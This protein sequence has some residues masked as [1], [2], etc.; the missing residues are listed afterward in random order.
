MRLN[1]DQPKTTKKQDALGFSDSA[2]SMAKNILDG[3]YPKGFV[4]GIDG[5]WGS[6]K[7][8]F[9]NFV[10]E[11]LKEQ[12]AEFLKEQSDESLKELPKEFRV[13]E[14]NPWLHSSHENLIAAYF[15]LLQENS[16][17]IFGDDSDIKETLGNVIDAFAPVGEAIANAISLGLLGKTVNTIMRLC[18]KELQKKPTLESQYKQIKETLEEVKQPFLVIID[19]LDRLDKTEIKTML[20]LVKSVGQLPYVTYILAYDRDY[21]ENATKDDMPDRKTT[22]LQKII[23]YTFYIPKPDKN[24]LLA[25]LN[26]EIEEFLK[27]IDDSN[28]RWHDLCKEALHPYIK[29]PRDVAL[30]TNGI[31]FRFHAVKEI[32]DPVDFF[33]LECLRLFDKNLWDWIRDNRDII[34]GEGVYYFLQYEKETFKKDVED[35]LSK[36][37]NVSENQKTTL[38]L[39]FPNLA[40]AIDENSYHVPENNY[41]THKRNGI[42]VKSAYDAYFSQHLDKTEVLQ[43]DIDSFI[44]NSHD[45]KKTTKTLKSW[46]DKKGVQGTPK[47]GEFL[48]LLNF[49]LENNPDHKPDKMLLWS[50]IDICDDINLIA[51]SLTSFSMPIHWQILFVFTYLFEQIGKQETKEFLQDVCND[52]TRTSAATF[53]LHSVGYDMGKMLNNDDTGKK[54]F[55]IEEADW[56]PLT[57]IIAPHIKSAFLTGTVGDFAKVIFA[58]LFATH[59]F[60]DK[61]AQDMFKTAYKKSEKYVIKTVKEHLRYVT[62][63]SGERGYEFATENY[64]EPIQPYIMEEYA[65]KVNLEKQD[66]D[67]KEAITVFLDGMRK[68]DDDYKNAIL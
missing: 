18:N 63:G 62:T 6:G 30:L 41:K 58:E 52:E 21:V 27:T 38:S 2:E 23:Q 10:R 14:F 25:I 67:T 35:S 11:S 22:F 31:N 26:K 15:K 28:K 47:I 65:K 55:F 66:E 36:F 19:D 60:G 48:N 34:L 16:N 53:L 54:R 40:N 51:K 46:I 1:P 59:I 8:S 32:L 20:K 49:E 9:I 3:K 50:L 61:I 44:E 29:E 24:K 64:K 33:T 13:L 17:D 68:H 43:S 5:N 57:K 42:A 4:I 12:Y 37:P 56:E 45:N 39:L 7:T